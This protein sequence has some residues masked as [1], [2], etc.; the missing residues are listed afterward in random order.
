MNIDDRITKL[1]QDN[2][3]LNARVELL[4]RMENYV[5]PAE[6]AKILHCSKNHIYIQIRSGAIQAVT[7]GAAIRI[8]MSQ[9][10]TKQIPN[11]K[12]TRKQAK[13]ELQPEK[14]SIQEIR[15]RVFE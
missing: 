9:F 1:E 10:E 12:P 5:T 3:E 2:I 11:K 8:P 13:P 4:S 7:V 14:P 6:L 15:N